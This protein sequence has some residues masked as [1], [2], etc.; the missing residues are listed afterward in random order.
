VIG[1]DLSHAARP[2]PRR[3]R[4]LSALFNPGSV[5]VVGA[6][7]D[8]AKWGNWIARRALRGEHRRPV[9][10]INRNGGE[11][12][13]RRAYQALA[14]V[15]GPTDLVVVAVPAAGFEA[16]VD[17]ALAV[18]ARAIV[19]IS[20]GLGESG[21]AGR[22]RERAVADRV[23]AAGAI[24]LGPNGLGVFDA[25][26][27]LDLTSNGFPS[28]SIGLVSQSG[29]LALELSL[30]A[31]DAGLGF[32]RFA[33]L[34]NQA[35]LD[36]A[37]LVAAFA[38]HDETH[39]IAVYCEDF[40]DG[41]A[42]ASAAATA[43]AQGKPVLLLTVGRS[44]ASARAARS[45]T[46]ALASASLAVDAACHAAGIDR[47]VT[48]HE[49]MNL[50][51]ALL[52][53]THPRGR[54][55]AIL[56]DGGGHGAIAAE[57][58]ARVRLTVPAFTPALSGCLRDGLPVTAATS[59]PIDLAGGGEQDIFSF[60]RTT[61]L[62][63]DTGEVDAV[64]ITGYFGGYGEYAQR[65]ARQE[66]D[67]ARAW[68]AAA[69]QSGKPLVV[70]TMYAQTAAAGLLR[71]ARIPVYRTIEAAC[72][73]LARLV[74][75]AERRP[76]GVPALPTPTAAITADDY[77]SA[78]RLLASAGVPFVAA[79]PVRTPAEALAAAAAI[80]YPV[81]L[82]AL[83]VSHKSDVGGVLVGITDASALTHA[84]DDL[85][86]RLAPPAFSVERMARLDKGV[87]L[88]IGVRRDRRFGPMALVGMG[89]LYTEILGDV[90]VALAPVDA[91]YAETLLRSLRGA[92][93]LLGYR[94]R[95]P[96]DVAGAARALA[97]LSLLAAA[98][99]EI[100]D[101]EVNPLL[102]SPDGVL[103]LDARIV[104]R[105]ASFAHDSGGTHPAPGRG[106]KAV[107]ARV[108]TTLY[109]YSPRGGDVHSDATA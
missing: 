26:A 66:L 15:P 60:E 70:H 39:L 8:G 103:G 62:L 85:R 93:L 32:S 46:G 5:A 11:I 25:G 102:V 54:R 107:M 52:A 50:A 63:L 89:G 86:L 40:R 37:E 78:R 51:Q 106:R 61:R 2:E 35:D 81:V 6:S 109:K 49:L 9:Y 55:V 59:N 99:P 17:E 53:G 94:G 100:D 97:D 92:P 79:Q 48:P 73:A 56:G 41:R 23:R 67:V 83:G 3:W 4:D 14:D 7:N 68:G 74:E 75:R 12:L 90:G 57:A 104:L 28:G 16:A 76:Q 80:G 1:S 13:G 22:A 45:H 43:V 71:G 30:L 36:V 27:E 18:G 29:N 108:R 33:S 96:C 64:L 101:V 21:P 42:F 91:E 34:G 10:L 65:L 31:A 44:A 38:V 88:L 98:H 105:Q 82:K 77:W 47:V 84:I 95:P 69:A 72:W 87:E 19:G 58:A 24:L 20:A